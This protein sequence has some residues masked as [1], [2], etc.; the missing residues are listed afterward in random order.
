MK[1]EDFGDFEVLSMKQENEQEIQEILEIA[2]NRY[3][4][5]FGYDVKMW[6]KVLVLL[7]KKTLKL[8]PDGIVPILLGLFHQ[9]HYFA[10]KLKEQGI[11]IRPS[12]TVAAFML[13]LMSDE[14][15]PETFIK[16]MTYEIEV[17]KRSP[18]DVLGF[19]FDVC[20]NMSI[21]QLS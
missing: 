7:S 16:F 15:P 11:E 6:R 21:A 19:S 12:S 10:V 17:K 4:Q 1:S 2:T 14:N 5:D 18:E 3:I 8:K 13:L 9:C 20:L